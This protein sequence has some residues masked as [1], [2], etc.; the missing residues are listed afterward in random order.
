MSNVDPMEHLDPEVREWWR[1]PV[2]R[3]RFEERMSHSGVSRRK[4]LGIIGAF[5]AGT[6]AIACGGGDDKD[7]APS[8]GQAPA[9][10][11][12]AA[13]QTSTG[14][15]KLAREQLYRN[16][17]T[18]EPATFDYSYNLYAMASAYP[19]AALLQ[20]DENY[21]L[22]PDMAERFTV[23]Q[24]GDVYTFNIRKDTKWSNGDPVTAQDFV[25]TWTRRLDPNSGAD[26]AAFL[27]DIKNGKKFNNKEITDP[28]LLGLKAVDDYTL[29]V[30]TEGPAGYFPAL[31][32]YQAAMPA[33]RKEVEKHGKTYGQDATKFVGNGPFKLTKWEHNKSFELVKNEQYWNA[34]NIKME[35]ITYLIVKQD[36]RVP[37]YENN[38]IDNVPSANVG[39]FKRVSSDPK[40][41]KEIFK[42]DQVGSWYLMPNPRFKPF[43]NMKVRLAMAHAIDRDTLV[44]N[45]LQGLGQVAYTQMN[46]G[47][48]F[49][50]SN[51]YDEFTK[52]DPKLAMEQLRGTE[53][54]GGKNWPKITMSMRAN[55]ADAHKASMAALVQMF[56][57]HLGMTIESEVG[58]PQAVYNEM[59]QGNKQLM[60]IRWYMD[61]PDPNN[62]HGDCF[63]SKI[64]AGSRRSWWENAEFD[65]LVEQGRTEPDLAKRQ[66]IY[67]KADDILVREAGAI[68]AYYPHAYGLRKPYIKGQPTNKE[69]QPVPDFNIYLREV[70]KLYK[71]DL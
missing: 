4:V 44:K 36:Q 27:Y 51:K 52:F 3:A 18:D 58:D 9:A 50:N 26:Y 15:E 11:T 42:F 22:K 16:T 43:D 17:V 62:A 55:E 12:T 67:K 38:E 30:T 1:D 66:A 7:D 63:Y 53:Y 14:N 33:N 70:E 2:Q 68:F 41:S 24:R 48:P 57:E 23:N 45:V 6:V 49:Y 21:N 10:G 59:R 35:R 60:W 71:V 65:S 47:S 39:D 37:T 64:P 25:W 46:P 19:L 13:G 32:A 40:L 5:T 31:A 34:P 61:Y 56:K 28:S 54:E 8:G 29:E 20:Y 69:G